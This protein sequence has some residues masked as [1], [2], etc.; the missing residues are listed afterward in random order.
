VFAVA[1]VGGAYEDFL[2]SGDRGQ[3]QSQSQQGKKRKAADFEA[4]QAHDNPPCIRNGD[5]ESTCGMPLIKSG[6]G[7]DGTPELSL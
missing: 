4:K 1:Y 5:S 6:G 3:I 7:I 2:R